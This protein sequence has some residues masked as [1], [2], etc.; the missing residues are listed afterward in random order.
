MIPEIGI[1]VGSYIAFRCIE[2]F[3]T[4]ESKYSGSTARVVTGV[5]AALALLVTVGVVLSLMTT[6]GTGL[7]TQ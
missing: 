7:P 6:S 5:A 2:T 1:M 4:A 3:C